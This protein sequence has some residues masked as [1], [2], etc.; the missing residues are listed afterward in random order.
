MYQEPSHVF[1]CRWLALINAS[2]ASEGRRPT[3]WSFYSSQVFRGFSY[4]SLTDQVES[5]RKLEVGNEG[6][7]WLPWTQ[8]SWFANTLT[9][10]HWLTDTFN[11]WDE[12]LELLHFPSLLPGSIYLL[13]P[14]G[15][16]RNLIGHNWY[17]HVSCGSSLSMPLWGQISIN[18]HVNTPRVPY[19]KRAFMTRPLYSQETNRSVCI[20]C[21]PV[22][23]QYRRLKRL[24]DTRWYCYRSYGF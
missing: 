21:I 5:Y 14:I 3:R 4:S 12:A 13:Y 2:M 24:S 17:F 20:C 10:L 6:I 8:I 16:R 23:S 7:F 1:S 15:T 22:K 18:R 11:Y 19:Q 9:D